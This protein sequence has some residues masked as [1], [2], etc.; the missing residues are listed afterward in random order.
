[1]GNLLR[2]IYLIPVYLYRSLLSP[3][4]GPR[5]CRYCP[6]C[7]AYFVTAVKRFGIIKGSIMGWARILR[8]SPFFLGGPD[9]VPEVWSWKEIRE[10][11]IIYRKRRNRD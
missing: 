3:L 4:L 5:K 8:C 1:M 6:S 2:N 11:W 9:E 10:K 7:S